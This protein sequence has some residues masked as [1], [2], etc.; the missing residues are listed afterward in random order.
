MLALMSGVQR[1]RARIDCGCCCCVLCCRD[2]V[3]QC[4]AK[5]W[6]L[7][8]HKER[9][10]CKAACSAVLYCAMLCYAMLC[11]AAM[12]CELELTREKYERLIQREKKKKNHFFWEHDNTDHLWKHP[13]VLLDN[14]HAAFLRG[15]CD[16]IFHVRVLGGSP[17]TLD[18]CSQPAAGGK[19][20]APPGLCSPAA[21]ALTEFSGVVFFF[22]FSFFWLQPAPFFSP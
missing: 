15:R 6:C 13:L 10:S 1:R 9:A 2:A 3:P 4:N 19:P 8:W 17:D 22:F 12:Q 7:D 5:P 18:A 14:T 11:Y 21:S 20:P 16:F